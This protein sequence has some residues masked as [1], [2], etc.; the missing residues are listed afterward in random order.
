MSSPCLSN[1]LCGLTWITIYRSPGWVS[2]SDSPSPE[3]LKFVPST[4][5]SGILISI[6]LVF[7]TKPR[8]SHSWHCSFTIFP[9]P[10]QRL[11]VDVVVNIPNGVLCVLVDVPRPLHSVHVII[12]SGSSA[13][14]PLHF[15]HCSALGMEIIFVVP[16]AASSSSI[17]M[18]YLKSEPRCLLLCL[19]PPKT[20]SKIL[21]KSKPIPPTPDMISEKSNP[22]KPAPP[23]NCWPA[24]PNWS[25]CALFWSSPNTAAASFISLNFSVESGDLFR[26][27]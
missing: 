21:S 7:S 2:L 10:L 24:A 13:P 15:G 17:S 3:T 23:W 27:G 9:W 6:F 18:S 26:S 1:V 4:A 12:S 19:P 22:S 8:P 11:Q 20:F 25:Y 16:N 5:P 14:V